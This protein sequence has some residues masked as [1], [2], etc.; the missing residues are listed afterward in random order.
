MLLRSTIW[1]NVF[2]RLDLNEDP[3][4]LRRIEGAAK[5]CLWRNL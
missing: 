1:Y 2:A 5:A 3:A 4:S